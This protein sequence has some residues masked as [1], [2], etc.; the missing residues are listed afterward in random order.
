[1]F[2]LSALPR[3]RLNMGADVHL[4]VDLEKSNRLSRKW[5]PGLAWPGLAWPGL[6]WPGLAWLG[7]AWPGLAWLGLAW[8]GLAE[9]VNRCSR[10]AHEL[11]SKRTLGAAQ[12]ADGLRLRSIFECHLNCYKAGNQ[13]YAVTVSSYGKKSCD[14]LPRQNG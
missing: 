9:L 11:L 12:V 1:M 7:L 14:A 2:G 6:A 5:R 4:L 13:T 8:L 10:E 3:H